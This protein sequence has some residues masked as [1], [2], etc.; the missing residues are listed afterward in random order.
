M[1]QLSGA[2]S[3][4]EP[5]KGSLLSSCEQSRFELSHSILQAQQIRAT[6]LATYDVSSDRLLHSLLGP[7]ISS[8]VEGIHTGN[9][10]DC[11]ISRACIKGANN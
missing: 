7:L 5:T 6:A 8:S 2:G 4:Y 1:A 10:S 11:R 3:S 9:K